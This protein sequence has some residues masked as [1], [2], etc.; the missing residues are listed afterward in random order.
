MHGVG[1]DLLG[2]D[3]LAGIGAAVERCGARLQDEGV[4]LD[5]YSMPHVIEDMEAARICSRLRAHQPH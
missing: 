2:D 5:G 3:S 4:D 1:K